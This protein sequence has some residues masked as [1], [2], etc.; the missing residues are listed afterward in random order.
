MTR[1]TDQCGCVNSVCDDSGGINCRWVRL[2]VRN[3]SIGKE[4]SDCLWMCKWKHCDSRHDSLAFRCIISLTTLLSSWWLQNY[5]NYKDEERSDKTG[6]RGWVT[7]AR[8]SRRERGNSWR[9]HRGSGCPWVGIWSV[10]LHAVA[11][12][13][14]SSYTRLLTGRMVVNYHSNL[15]Q[16]QM[17]SLEQWV[18]RWNLYPLFVW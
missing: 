5:Q 16:W 14:T 13:K 8:W 7:C 17:S 11:A 3:E 18:V 2:K 9:G 1:S 10:L 6:E 12:V 15:S 4:T